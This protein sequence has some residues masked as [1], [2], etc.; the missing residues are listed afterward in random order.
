MRGKAFAAM[1]VVAGGLTAV[2]ATPARAWSC[3]GYSPPAPSSLS[4][5]NAQRLT[6]EEQAARAAKREAAREARKAE[7]LAKKEAREKAAAAKAATA[8]ASN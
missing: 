1:M 6:P 8:V 2:T 4:F 3:G 7:K 5:D